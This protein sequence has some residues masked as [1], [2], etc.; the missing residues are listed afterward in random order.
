MKKSLPVK[1]IANLPWFTD[2]SVGSADLACV[3]HKKRIQRTL[4]ALT[5]CYACIL[6]YLG[7]YMADY[8]DNLDQNIWVVQAPFCSP[9]YLI[10]QNLE[11]YTREP[12]TELPLHH[13]THNKI[14][15][16]NNCH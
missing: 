8:Q 2:E 16:L 14:E 13:D 7:A 12:P 15:Q 10:S 4:T 9:L 5:E 1:I 3:G 11:P 6:Y